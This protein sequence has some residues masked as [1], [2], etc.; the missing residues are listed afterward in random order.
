MCGSN[1]HETAINYKQVKFKCDFITTFNPIVNG[2]FVQGSSITCIRLT[3]MQQQQRKSTIEMTGRIGPDQ[4]TQP[5][6]GR[7]GSR[8]RRPR[9]SFN[10]VQP[11]LV[12]KMFLHQRTKQSHIYQESCETIR[13]L[14]L[15]TWYTS[16]CFLGIKLLF[17]QI[18]S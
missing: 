13:H 18:E 16:Y 15:G 12:V 7:F 17:V 1:F 6:I 3:C 11:L 4:P 10:S 9:R 8:C 2:G 5:K 14:L